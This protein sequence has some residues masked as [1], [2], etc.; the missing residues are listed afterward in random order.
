MPGLPER[1]RRH[2]DSLERSSRSP[3][4]VVLMRAAADDIEAGGIVTRLFESVDVPRGSVPTLRLL[5]ALHH[6]VL[7][8]R[9]AE[10]AEFYP[11]AGGTRPAAGVWPVALT[12][13]EEHFDWVHGRLGLTIQTNE[14]GRAAVLYAALL[15]LTE[16]RGMPIRLLELGASAGLNL[17]V[18]RYCYVVDGV[19]LGDPTSPVRLVEPWRPGPGIDVEGAARRLRIVERSG[20]DLAPLKTTDRITLLSYIWPDE[21]ERTGRTRAAL[22]LAAQDPPPV[23]AAGATEWLRAQPPP[24]GDALTV[25]WHSVFRQYLPAGEWEALEAAHP[26]SAVWLAME[27]GHDHI[28]HMTLTLRETPDEPPQL[29]AMCGDHG[30]PVE[31]RG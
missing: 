18:D 24:S 27:P 29:L 12:A 3:L 30:A 23:A 20:C 10:L 6:L 21:P 17:L 31:W 15:W 25:I 5:A 22:D 1:F 7:E 2:A 19:A 28:R 9:A 4:Y 8:G 11:S 16:R 14:P 26:A 13:L